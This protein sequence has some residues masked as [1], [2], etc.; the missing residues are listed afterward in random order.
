[1]ASLDLRRIL[2]GWDYEANQITVRKIT[3]DDGTPKI[4][5]RLDLGLL[6]MEVSGRPDGARPHGC[7]CLLAYHEKRLADHVAKNGTELGFELTA[8]D[9]QALREESLQYYHRYLAEFVLEDFEGVERD[10]AR[11]LR[12]LDLCRIHAREVADR[13]TLE[14]YR[15][16]LIMM[17]TRA[18]VHVA[19]RRGTFKTALARVNAGLSMIHE[20]LADNGQEEMFEEMTEVQILSSLRDEIATRMPK[21][22]LRRL[23]GELQKAVDE[24]RYED[25]AVLRNRME[26]MKTRHLKPAPRKRRK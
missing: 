18:Q 22:P 2:S 9:C 3:G 5:M 19:L 16:Y 24:E 10:A 8:P 7:D 17:H 15:P 12:V 6:Q 1:M 25:A 21:D 14:Q 4:Q 23:E 20:V 13:E 11:N 26:A